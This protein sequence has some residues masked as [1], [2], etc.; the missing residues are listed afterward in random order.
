V[1]LLELEI[2][3]ACMDGHVIPE[4]EVLYHPTSDVEGVRMPNK[5]IPK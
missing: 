3:I 4:P 5:V 2:P 1:V